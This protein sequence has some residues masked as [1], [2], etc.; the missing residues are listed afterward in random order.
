[1]TLSAH[2]RMELIR[3]I[4][5]GP[6]RVRRLPSV[7]LLAYETGTVWVRRDDWTVQT[8]FEP[9]ES[10]FLGQLGVGRRAQEAVENGEGEGLRTS[11]ACP[12]RKA[13]LDAA[14][15]QVR[16]AL[17]VVPQA[18]PPLPPQSGR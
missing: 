8:P 16:S 17:R 2:R 12:V 18:A 1:M 4:N 10:E 13:A 11:Y 7:V 9:A 6:S 5:L 3:A 14:L 15:G